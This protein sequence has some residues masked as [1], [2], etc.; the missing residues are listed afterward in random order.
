MQ[1]NQ[2]LRVPFCLSEDLN[3]IV[4]ESAFESD[5]YFSFLENNSIELMT[6]LRADDQI[7]H[8]LVAR[9]RAFVQSCFPQRVHRSAG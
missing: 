2:L 5:P 8:C 6:F 4:F 9:V 1:R 3:E 7:W